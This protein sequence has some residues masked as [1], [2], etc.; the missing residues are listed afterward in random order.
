MTQPFEAELDVG[1]RAIGAY[2]RL[3]YT[4]WHALAEFIDNSTQS[5]L[6][7]GGIIDG[8]LD[9]EGTPLIVEITHD[10]INKTI[11]IRDNSI[12][13]SRDDLVAALK[14]AQPTADSKGRSKYG[15]GM[16]TAACWIGNRWKVVTAE[17]SSGMEW[18]ADVDIDKVAAGGRVP[19]TPRPVDGD[20]HYTEIIISGLNRHI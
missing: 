1:P 13:M 9:K 16:K 12:G 15:M 3:S 8:V 4:M 11:S 6:N 20:K 17:W 14:I 7:Y 10:R 19:I 2:S 18:T 5:R